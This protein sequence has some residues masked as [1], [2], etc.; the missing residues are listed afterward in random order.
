MNRKSALFIF[1][2]AA[3]FLVNGCARVPRRPS[4][5]AMISQGVVPPTGIYITVER[6]QTLYRIAKKYSID[7][8]ELMRVNGIFNPSQLVV[9]QRVF[10]PTAPA[11]APGM[12]GFEPG[13]VALI[14]SLVGSRHPLSDWRTI[15][16]HHSGTTQG[17]A[18]LFDRDHHRRHMGGLFYHFVIGNG[19]N[20]GDGE[21][22]VGWRWQ[23]QVKANRPYDVQ[24]C[25]VGNFD[26]QQVSEAQF[27]SLVILINT[28]RAEYSIPIQNI[29]Q[30]RDI[31]GKHTDCPGKNFPF[32]RLISTLSSS[33]V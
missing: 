4:H 27:N 10:I 32:H 18:K 28:L 13:K 12:A 7:V 15:T 22:E 31:K 20:T 29:R 3:V 9:G 19:T 16:V 30:H 24:I 14:G 1:L 26:E 33:R 11:G 2:I 8:N 25:L 23:S 5:R 21:V 6:G 17:S